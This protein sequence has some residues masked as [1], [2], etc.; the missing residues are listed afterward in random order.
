MT[1]TSG[2]QE[3]VSPGVPGLGQEAADCL[4]ACL[5]LADR[6]LDIVRRVYVSHGLMAAAGQG[7]AGA[8][9]GQR[10][11]RMSSWM[12]SPGET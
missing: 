8:S 10:R 1:P 4:V 3:Y 12:P 5:S 9:T 6:R 2:Y 7:Q 11:Q